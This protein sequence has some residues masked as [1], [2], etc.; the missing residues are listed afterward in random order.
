MIFRWTVVFIIPVLGF[1]VYRKWKYWKSRDPD[2]SPTQ[3]FV[4]GSSNS[5]K[6]FKAEKWYYDYPYLPHLV[7]V[8]ESKDIENN[9]LRTSVWYMRLI[10]NTGSK[11]KLAFFTLIKIRSIISVQRNFQFPTHFWFFVLID[12][13]I[14]NLWP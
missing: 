12:M 6:E 9:D 4:T 14:I 2:S 13:M 11:I 5:S 8:S 7:H 3:V 10:Y 1:I